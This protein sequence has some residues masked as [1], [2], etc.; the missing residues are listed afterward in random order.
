MSKKLTA[1]QLEKNNQQLQKEIELLKEIKKIKGETTELTEKEITAQRLVLAQDADRALKAGNLREAY[2]KQQIALKAISD[3][4]AALNSLEET[5]D[6]LQIEANKER[7]KG[8]IDEAKAIEERIKN[9]N[10]EIDIRDKEIQRYDEIIKK[11]EEATGAYKNLSAAGKKNAEEAEGF[12]SSLTFGALKAGD[13]Q[14]SAAF[15]FGDLTSRMMHSTTA[16]AEFALSFKQVFNVQNIAAAALDTVIDATKQM[17]TQFDNASAKFAATTGLAGGYNDVLLKVQ[18]QS[19][20]FGISAAEGG[21][22]MASLLGGFNDFH[23]SSPKVQKDLTI[24]VAS[25]GKLGVS[26]KQSTDMLNNMNKFM[27]MSGTEALAASKKIG[28]MGTKIGITTSKMLTD[29]DASLK[30]LAVYGDKSIDVFTG[31]AAAAK[32]AGVETGTLLGLA[33]KF[34]T[35]SGAAETTGKLNAILGSQLSATE[36]L[37]ASEDQRIKTLIGSVQATGQA[38]GSMDKFTQKA[39]ANAAGITD[40]AEANKIFGMSM[41]EYE[42]YEDQMKSSTNAQAQFDEVMKKVTPTFEKLRLIAAEF[43][44]SFGPALEVAG[45]VIQGILD[46]VTSLN[47]ASGGLFGTIVGGAAGL[48]LFAA[49]LGGI[50][51]MLN[52]VSFGLFKNIGLLAKK[53]AA[54]LYN[55]T[56]GKT[57]IAQKIT[58]LG[59]QA[60]G[61]IAD[62]VDIGQKTTKNTLTQAQASAELRL[63]MVQRSK[64]KTQM[65]V[66]KANTASVGPML[67]M[68]AAIMMI[69]TGVYFAATGLGNLVAAFKGLTG[70]QLVAA[71]LALAAF[72]VGLLLLVGILV[73]L[74]A[75]PQAA[76]VAGGVGVLLAIGG[77]IALIGLGV[78]LA[79]A[80]F[81]LMIGA[82]AIPS[83]E[84]Y[85]A[86]GASMIMFGVGLYASAAGMAIFLPA[87]A[88]FMGFLLGMAANPLAWAAVGLLAAIAGSIFMIGL[89]AKLAIDSMT[90]LISTIA[91]SEGLGS[92]LDSLFG[93]GDVTVS[94][95]VEKRVEIVN[96]LISDVSE[97]DIKS[98]LENI[99][100]ITTGVSAGLMTENTVSNLTSVA[101]L[102]DTIKNIFNPE[103]TIEMDSGAVEKLFKEGIYK[104]N[105][106]T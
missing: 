84:Q 81:S 95:G 14:K 12:F 94:A 38:F 10:L 83:V 78:G 41:S 3:T 101:S 53:A 4:Q 11:V 22:A 96:K 29:Y 65:L 86:F 57:E 79:A 71:G 46:G 8:N 87:F 13:A 45:D 48:T 88:T 20:R 24:G 32:A 99:A 56:L 102:A 66:N 39:I 60:K 19:N 28:M 67:A 34:D 42:N 1:E 72:G 15:K 73:G 100:L 9:K 37:T 68:G 90:E 35:F 51:K 25:L 6:K 47:D 2:E 26:A 40:M 97:A 55:A 103:I 82:I 91:N 54:S 70:G 7:E 49:G 105:R 89:G 93:G 77:A 30:T 50:G 80:G 92:I 61:K 58:K 104:V 64:L 63:Q 44:V 5:R 106:S 36:M 59:L 23:R 98:D 62:L 16:A 52:F 43:A 33:E 27:G 17:V 18:K 31:I 21:A 74:V 75:G 69:G 76:F 85:L